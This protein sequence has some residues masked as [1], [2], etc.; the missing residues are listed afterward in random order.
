[1]A[2]PQNIHQRKWVRAG[3]C[4]QGCGRKRRRSSWYCEPCAATNAKASAQRVA[5]LAANGLCR[6]GEPNGGHRRCDD[7][8]ARENRAR[9][10]H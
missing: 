3:L 10:K 7:C 2:S 5:R 9:R 1:M 6:C 4:A 8:R